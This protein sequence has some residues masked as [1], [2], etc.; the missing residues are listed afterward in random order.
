MEDTMWEQDVF[1]LGLSQQS[2]WWTGMPTSVK[3]RLVCSRLPITPLYNSNPPL[4]RSNFRFPSGHSLYNFTTL[5]NSNHDFQYVTS[6][7]EQCTVGQDIEFISKKPC[8]LCPFWDIFS[9]IALSR[10]DEPCS[11][12]VSD[13]CLFGTPIRFQLLSEPIKLKFIRGK[14][15][16]TVDNFDNSL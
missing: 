10:R 6:Q 13:V 11:G 1:T 2:N 4:T 12:S 3:W 14:Q 5:D 8:N 7:N 9:K 15:S 16:D